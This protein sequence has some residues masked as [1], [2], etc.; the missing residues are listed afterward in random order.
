MFGRVG[1]LLYFPAICF[2]FALFPN[3]GH[4][5]QRRQNSG[6]NMVNW[7]SFE[8]CHTQLN[9]C[10]EN[11]SPLGDTNGFEGL[12]VDGRLTV[13]CESALREENWNC[14]SSV[15]HCEDDGLYNVIRNS[16]MTW[17]FICQNSPG[18]VAGEDCWINMDLNTTFFECLGSSNNVCIPTCILTTVS[19][20]PDC[21]TEDVALLGV[22]I[23][24]NMPE[25]QASC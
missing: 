12:V 23:Q 1:F 18:F 15:S 24:I 17:D 6:E 7:T 14:I 9:P 25:E 19:K 10:L 5:T 22:L 3:D 20:I 21:S 13:P 2:S 8:M 4:E 11:L 16:Q